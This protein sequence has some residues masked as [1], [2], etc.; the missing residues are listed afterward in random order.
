MVTTY[1][2]FPRSGQQGHYRHRSFGVFDHWLVRSVARLLLRVLP[3]ILGG[4]RRCPT[5]G[6]SD[7]DAFYISGRCDRV[8]QPIYINRMSSM[9][10]YFC[11]SCA[12]RE[13]VS[14]SSPS[15]RQS[16]EFSHR[17]KNSSFSYPRQ[18]S[19]ALNTKVRSAECALRTEYARNP[20]ERLGEQGF[21]AL[22]M[23]ASPIQALTGNSQ[24]LV[25]SCRSGVCG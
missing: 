13:V 1:R 18:E 22:G 11:T 10:R 16:F 24:A 2:P 15:L 25:E 12:L 19:S 21:G 4:V 7:G 6:S 5:Q 8:N 23:A 17:P 20:P 3:T 14:T 9:R